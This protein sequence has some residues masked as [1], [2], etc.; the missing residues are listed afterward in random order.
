MGFEMKIVWSKQAKIDY[1]KILDYLLE[2]WGIG[3]LASFIAKTDEMLEAIKK[4]PK[5]FIESAKK[6]RTLEKLLLPSTTACSIKL[7]LSKRRLFCLH[8]GTI[9]KI[10][11]N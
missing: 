3:V 10:L 8:F 4:Q 7:S 2:K 9:G 1:Y 11:K 6:R 5:S